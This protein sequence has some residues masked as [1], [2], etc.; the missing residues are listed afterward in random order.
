MRTEYTKPY[1]IRLT[2]DEFDEMLEVFDAM[3]F[4]AGEFVPSDERISEIKKRFSEGKAKRYLLF[5]MWIEE[6]GVT[7]PE[8]KEKRKIISKLLK[9][10][11]EIIPVED[12]S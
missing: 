12:N 9:D 8:N 11:V 2:Y 3:D 6:T 5:L 10:F 7:I 4:T 1:R